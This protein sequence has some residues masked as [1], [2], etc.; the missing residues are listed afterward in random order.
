[1]NESELIFRRL[2]EPF[3]VGPTE[4]AP[5]FWLIA[6]VLIPVLWPPIP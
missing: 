4:Y 1:M 6:T 2:T 3:P 5:V